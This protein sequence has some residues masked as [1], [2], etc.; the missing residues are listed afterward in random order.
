[1]CGRFAIT[2]PPEAM[3]RFFRYV[4]NPNFPPRYNV[5]PTQP[6]PVVRGRRGPA[7]VERRFDLMRWGFLPPFVKDPGQFPLI[8]NAR[9]ET[10][11]TRA[12]FRTAFKRRRCLFIADAFY[13]WRREPA[14]ARRGRQRALPYL[15]GRSDGAPLG[16]GGIWD[17][18]T[19]PNG[20]EQD[21]ACIVTTPANGATAAIHDRLPAIIEPASFD[22]WLDPD[23][24]TAGA[25]Y[26]L[27]RPPGNEV[28][29][30]FEIGAAVNKASNDGPELQQ[31]IGP[32]EPAAPEAAAPLQG[33]LF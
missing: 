4:E 9:C 28:L 24:S 33:S 6:V 14:G 25:A 31:P 21:T 15:F 10:L 5:A 11:P 20:E 26:A 2:L 1:M 32:V 22:I 3:R 30:F 7:G 16:L 29:R 18:W 12:S 17:S 8:V 19:G 23:E 13:E 27:L